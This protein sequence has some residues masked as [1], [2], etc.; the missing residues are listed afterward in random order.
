VHT[1]QIYFID[2][3][4]CPTGD[5]TTGIRR[6][7]LGNTSCD[8]TPW[9]E[10]NFP[11][12]IIPGTE[13]SDYTGGTRERSNFRVLVADAAIAANVVVIIGG[14]GYTALAHPVHLGP[15]PLC[16]ELTELWDALESGEVLDEDDEAEMECM[17]IGEAWADHGCRDF[18]KTLVHV[19]A[20]RDHEPG[21]LYHHELPLS[22][23]DE[24]PQVLEVFDG[25][26]KTWGDFWLDLWDVGCEALGINGG[27]GSKIEAGGSVYFYIDEWARLAAHGAPRGTNDAASLEFFDVLDRVAK[28]LRVV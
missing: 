3:A 1:Q 20:A 14:H 6:V 2:P 17:M 13:H 5:I 7:H 18:K 12:A 19:L 9:R 11:I 4:T 16:D 25:D 26:A 15:V 24:L 22:D 27:L 21:K 28:S 23:D 10:L 8:R